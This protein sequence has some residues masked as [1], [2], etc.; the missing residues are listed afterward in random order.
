MM[1]KATQSAAGLMAAE[2]ASHVK[3]KRLGDCP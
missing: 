2:V 3:A 1:T